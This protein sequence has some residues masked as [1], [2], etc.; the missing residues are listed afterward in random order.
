MDIVCH[1][2]CKSYTIGKGS[3]FE[4]LHDCDAVFKSGEITVITGVSGSGKTTLLNIIALSAKPDSGTLTYDETNPFHIS[5]KEQSRFR[6]EN[7]GYLPQNLGLIP[8]L[9]AE[10]N[11][12]MP[13]LLAGR[14][15]NEDSLFGT[16]YDPLEI[17]DCLDKFPHEL[18]GGQCQRVAI[19]RAI[20]N[21][22]KVFIADEPTSHLDSENIEKFLSL[23]FD[24]KEKGTTIILATHDQRLSSCADVLLHIR[25]GIVGKE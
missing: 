10:E 21:E 11:I 14:E 4:I 5:R 1:K 19:M 16:V 23:L 9:T 20:A 25:D 6:R 24:L 7:I 2:I 22:P 12:R 3:R 8:I 17:K 15:K 18:S 13:L